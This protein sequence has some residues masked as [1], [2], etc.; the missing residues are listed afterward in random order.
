MV[1]L[2]SGTLKIVSYFWRDLDYNEHEFKPDEIVKLE[3]AIKN[4]I[5]KLK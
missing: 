3:K 1:I 4:D 2:I 5:K